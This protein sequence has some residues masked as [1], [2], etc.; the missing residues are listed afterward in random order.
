MAKLIQK[1][2]SSD[3]N[4]SILLEKKH[5]DKINCKFILSK[6]FVRLAVLR[7]RIKRIIRNLSGAPICC[8]FKIK[9]TI[10]KKNCEQMVDKI[11]ISLCNS[12]YDVSTR[13]F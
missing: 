12:K 4:W 9:T 11:K 5:L 10:N 8:Y 7:N 3:Y 1:Y 2:A 13:D 6:K